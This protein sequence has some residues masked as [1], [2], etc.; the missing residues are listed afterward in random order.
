MRHHVVI[1][2][3]AAQLLILSVFS[4]L[5][6]HA[7]ATSSAADSDAYLFNLSFGDLKEELATARRKGQLSLFIMF[8]DDDC[9][10]CEKMKSAV[11]SVPKVQQFYRKYFGVLEVD[12]EGDTP[13]TDF[14]GREMSAKDFAFRGSL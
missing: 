3:F 6:G 1:T 2:V 13:V 9:P 5:P 8:G 10:W 4:L 12:T 14:S 11:F 7:M